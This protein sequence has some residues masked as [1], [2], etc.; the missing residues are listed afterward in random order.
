MAPRVAIA[1]VLAGWAVAVCS[2]AGDAAG[3][4][5]PWGGDYPAFQ[6][7]G[8][9]ALDGRLGDL[10]DFDVQDSYERG[11]PR[12]GLLPFLY[13]PFVAALYAPLALLPY[14]TSYALFTLLAFA[15]LAGAVLVMRPISPTIR[16]DPWLAMAMVLL[17]YPMCRAV[18]G[19]QNTALSLIIL[20]G[21]WR[22]LQ[23]RR[24]LLAG[25]LLGVLAYKPQL[26]LPIAGVVFLAGRLRAASGIAVSL[27]ALFAVSGVLAG[28]D[29]P[30]R[31]LHLAGQYAGPDRQFN[32]HASIALGQI[33]DLLGWA[34]GW[35]LLSGLLSLWVARVAWTS[36]RT[37][38]FAVLAIGITASLLIPPH[39]MFYDAGIALPAL[40]LLA[41]RGHIR[42]AAL[43]WAGGATQ[44]AT[45][46]LP[47]SPVLF[48]LLAMLVA[49]A[50]VV[51]RPVES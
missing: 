41:D 40:L 44:L 14:R 24:D 31:W 38:P 46:A 18:L 3:G 49:L 13:P 39:S 17:F 5:R 12:D 25:M 19:G 4:A 23:A 22:L 29:W 21:T 32:L 33:T 11:M 27:V 26:L 2:G 20:C 48:V 8:K 45:S 51:G 28:R 36:G 42:E 37:D 15:S 30:A 47:V 16:R 6:M 10:Y 7:A 1:G 43:L 50:R 9:I 34:H 35:L